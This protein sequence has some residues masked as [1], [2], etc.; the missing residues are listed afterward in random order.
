MQP[1]LLLVPWLSA[2]VCMPN[3]FF[4]TAPCITQ[5][6]AYG[7]VGVSTSG[8]CTG[9]VHNNGSGLMAATGAAGTSNLQLRRAAR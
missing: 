2:V 7:S 6:R 9:C 8:T 1:L 4:S 3:P 5:Q